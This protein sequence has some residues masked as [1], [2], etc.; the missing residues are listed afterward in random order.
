[1]RR[2][3]VWGCFF[4]LLLTTNAY[5]HITGAFGDFMLGIMA[6]NTTEKLH[7]EL[8]QTREQIENLTPKV[9]QLEK[10]YKKNEKVAASKLQF[11][12]TSGMDVWMDFILQSEGVVD[13]LSNQRIMEK[14]IEAYLSELNELYMDYMQ[15]KATKESLEGHEELLKV[16]E[17]NLQARYQFFADHSDLMP[18]EMEK[19]ILQIWG[20]DGAAFLDEDLMDDAWMIN[21]NIHEFVTRKTEDSPYRLEEELLNQ[22]SKLK[23]YFRTD[24]IYVHYRMGE[25]DVIL[26]GTLSNREGSLE[27]EAGFLNG[28][29]LSNEI[30]DQLQVFSIDYSLLDPNS[31]GF[32]VEQTNHAIIIQ[33]AE[34][35]GE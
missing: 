14:N 4:S 3:I 5:A 21:N 8:I 29:I 2:W 13:V 28:F 7:T 26:I 31:K 18:E 35:A 27:I 6:E 11:Y 1:M 20:R 17:K 12:N 16:I 19:K 33:P 9:D 22:K 23:Y 32:Y 25:A 24:H 15:V 34:K 10:E 30:L